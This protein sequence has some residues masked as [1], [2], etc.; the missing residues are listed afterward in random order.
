MGA[1]CP[2]RLS[3]SNSCQGS[4]IDVTLATRNNQFHEYRLVRYYETSYREQFYIL[5]LFGHLKSKRIGFVHVIFDSHRGWHMVDIWQ[6]ALF[7]HYG[8][9][10]CCFCSL[11]E[12]DQS[13]KV[14][15][16]AKIA[17]EFENYGNEWQS[18]LQEYA[19]NVFGI[20]PWQYFGK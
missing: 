14:L 1:F 10:N 7:D 19:E 20:M 16:I 2:V 5:Y 15:W 11:R 6:A 8:R 12:A 4:T 17:F 3:E 9:E 18:R 13:K